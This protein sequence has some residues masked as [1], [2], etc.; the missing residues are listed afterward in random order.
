[1]Q[2]KKAAVAIVAALLAG[3]SS[4]WLPWVKEERPTGAKWTP[5]GAKGYACEGGK[6]LL[7]RFESDG[8]SVWVIYPDRQLRLDR[9]TSASGEEW[10]RAGTTLSVKD[11]AATLI[12]GTAVQVTNCKP[13]EKT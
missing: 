4:S 1:M 13:E 11:G 2:G 10:S 8:K 5:A 3:C 7:V 9:V 12:E 6:R